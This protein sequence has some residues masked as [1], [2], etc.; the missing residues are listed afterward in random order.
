LLEPCEAKVSSTDLRGAA[1]GDTCG[2]PGDGYPGDEADRYDILTMAW[3]PTLV[4]CNTF[5]EAEA[6]QAAKV[7]PSRRRGRILEV[8]R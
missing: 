5:G 4:F 8:L 1:G 7:E 2:L 6:R 3:L